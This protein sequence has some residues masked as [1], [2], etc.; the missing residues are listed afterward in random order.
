MLLGTPLA[1]QAIL[2]A[3]LVLELAGLSKL[4]GFQLCGFGPGGVCALDVRGG[5]CCHCV[6]S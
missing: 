4:N 5:C 3:S 2:R 6:P 1:L